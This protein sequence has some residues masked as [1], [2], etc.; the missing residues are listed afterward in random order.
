MGKY[1]QEEKVKKLKLSE[2]L[3]LTESEFKYFLCDEKN[4]EPRTKYIMNIVGDIELDEETYKI[5]LKQFQSCGGR[6]DVR[7][8]EVTIKGIYEIS[9]KYPFLTAEALD[10][11]WFIY[12]QDLFEEYQLSDALEY[13]IELHGKKDQTLISYIN[14]IEEKV[15]EFD[16]KFYEEATKLNIYSKEYD[17]ELIKHLQYVIKT[18]HI[19]SQ[20]IIKSLPTPELIKRDK[21]QL[22]EIINKTRIYFGACHPISY[23]MIESLALGKGLTNYPEQ[24]KYVINKTEIIPT[25]FT[26][27]EFLDSIK[28][29]EEL[30]KSTKPKIKRK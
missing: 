21:K 28:E 7:T 3:K 8:N 26:K 19:Y 23:Q 14:Y 25:T 5:F 20:Q 27:K 30:E 16:Q 13:F 24:P 11:I 2:Y 12:I 6:Y 9:K 15:N 4:R 18:Q 1:F 22:N 17:Q 10:E 29:R